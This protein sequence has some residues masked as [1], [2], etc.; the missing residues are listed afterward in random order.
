MVSME[1]AIRD[2]EEIK[3]RS[4]QTTKV[5]IEISS[6]LKRINQF[7]LDIIKVLKENNKQEDNNELEKVS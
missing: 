6:D 4:K 7:L 2:V 1:Q 5:L 3:E